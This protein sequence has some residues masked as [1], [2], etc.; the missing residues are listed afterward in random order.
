MAVYGQIKE[1]KVV[2]LE[3]DLNAMTLDDKGCE[4]YIKTKHETAER[5]GR[6]VVNFKVADPRFEKEHLSGVN[7]FVPK[8]I[9]DNN[10]IDTETYIECGSDSCHLKIVGVEDW[11][12]R[13]SNGMTQIHDKRYKDEVRGAK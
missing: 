9:I 13:A 2:T 10:L 12:T 7:V 5:E 3:D 4:S 6:Y 8:G 11:F 1:F